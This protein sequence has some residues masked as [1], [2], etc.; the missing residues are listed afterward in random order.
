MWEWIF[1]LCS[2]LCVLFNFMREV[3]KFFFVWLLL[4]CLVIFW[5]IVDFILVIVVLLLFIIRV[6]IFKK[7][8][9]QLYKVIF[10]LIFNLSIIFISNLFFF[11]GLKQI[12]VFY[13]LWLVLLIWLIF[14]NFF[15]SY[16]F[17]VLYFF[18]GGVVD[19]I[20]FI[21]QCIINIF[22]C[23]VVYQIGMI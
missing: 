20:F 14:F 11:F 7:K 9:C 4:Y 1:V 5:F 21:F 16:V 17:L 2:N 3:V 18:F 23:F 22:I 12:V 6:D 15:C 10:E 19:M 13:K 8:V